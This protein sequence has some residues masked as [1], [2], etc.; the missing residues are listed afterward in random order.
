MPTGTTEPDF[1]PSQLA[2]FLRTHREAV[3]ERWRVAVQDRPASQGLSLQALI[4]HIPDLLDAI[5]DT[6]EDH[7]VD[8]T[9]RLD[10]ETAERHA[11]ARLEEG[12]DLSQVVIEL[13]VLRDCIL[14]VWDRERAPGAAR[15]EVRFLNRSV[16][17]AMAASIE[18]YTSAR[19]RTLKALDRISATALEARRLDD[20][21]QRLLEVMV[22]TTAAVDAGAILLRDR[23]DLVLRAAVG[24]PGD[25]RA[26]S[27][28]RIGDGFIGRVAAEGRA[29]LAPPALLKTEAVGPLLRGRG[30]S[31]VYGVPLVSE[32]ALVGVAFIGSETAPE[33]SEQDRR[34]FQAL[35][36]RATSGI[37]QHLLQATAETRAAELA[38]VI[39]AIPDAV[40]VGDANGFRHANRAAL[41]ML[42]AR[43]IEDV[44]RRFQAPGHEAGIR[45][46]GTGEPIPRAQWPFVRALRGETVSEEIAVA[47]ART[48]DDIVVRTAAAPVRLGE[49]I[50]GAVV[51]ATDV[52]GQKQ[53]AQERQRLLERAEQAVADR[54]HVLGIVSHELRNPLNTVAIAAAVLRELSSV[55]EAAQKS[56]ASI[57]RSTQRMS[58]M[59]QDL[60]D[61]SSIQAGRLAIDPRPLD[62][63]SLAEEAADT[64]AADAAGRGLTLAL[65]MDDALPMI[66]ADRDRLFQALANLV[67]NAL[68][69]TTSGGVVVG[70]RPGRGEGVVFS[71]RDTGPGIP[72][73][74]QGRLFEPYWRGR[75]T[76]QGSGLGLAI[77]RG[78]VE[79]HGGRIW[80]EST[81]GSGTT[82][83]FTVPCA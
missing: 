12:L 14:Q 56:I 58:R 40:L 22:E 59:I 19:D 8:S 79:T 45:R 32:D 62:P 69:V 16:D 49:R 7:V 53:A 10:T 55:P 52:T 61:L 4:D 57:I 6:G 33:F 75:S 35:A 51:V 36:A 17:R 9:S 47:D 21:L 37:V 2:D 71:V 44:N 67:G 80:V 5:A 29:L 81:P 26:R 25:G 18:R 13:A 43:S 1:S 50:A 74:Q 77:A 76:Y 11:L 83:F 46:A 15:P 78:V 70:I 73:E 64:F 68:K 30:L 66:R 54:D 63:R 41:S 34:L 31:S 27:A 72:L 3:L 65:E 48:G 24:L 39:E 23:D 60:L 42:A 28:V 20:L 82:F 38:A